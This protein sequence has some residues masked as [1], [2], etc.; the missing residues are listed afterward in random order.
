MSETDDI[1]ARISISDLVSG[2]GVNL[3]RAGDHMVACCPLHNEKTPSFHVFPDTG[4]WR[5][6]GA[7]GKGGDIFDF[8]C[9][10]ENVEFRDALIELAKRAGVELKPQGGGKQGQERR[11]KLFGVLAA[12]K[13]FYE[14]NL[15]AT[16]DASALDYISSRG[17]SQEMIAEWGIG[18]APAGWR[19][20]YDYLHSIGYTDDQL[21]LDSGAFK[22]GDKGGVYDAFRDRLI[23]PIT[24]EAGQVISFAGRAM[25]KEDN[26]K[27]LNGSATEIFEKNSV[28]FGFHQA[29]Q[30]IRALNEVVLVEG[31][32]DV[33]FAH[34][35]GFKSVVGS[36]GTAFTPAH[37]ELLVKRGAGRVVLAFDPDKAGDNANLRGVITMQTVK[38]K[39]IDLRVLRLPDERDPDELILA[40]PETWRTLVQDATP[41]VLFVL[42]MLA[43]HVDA[44]TQYAEREQIARTILPIITAANT[45]GQRRENVARLADYVRIAADVLQGYIKAPPIA[46]DS[47]P[48]ARGTVP[49]VENEF[50]AGII[51]K[52]GYFALAQRRCNTLQIGKLKPHDLTSPEHRALLDMLIAA[53]DQVD[54]DDAEYIEENAPDILSRLYQR[55]SGRAL[56]EEETINAGLWLRKATFERALLE[57]QAVPEQVDL[58][59]RLIRVLGIA[60]RALQ[61]L[62]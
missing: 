27:Y 10:K 40:E 9:E 15:T 41:A 29:K 18:Y 49:E 8:Y 12:L 31:Y 32:M 44:K 37:A 24:N 61:K 38:D 3:K 36:M 21:L 56:G 2:Y 30:A 62:C 22:R 34:L 6:F 4:R 45:E 42:D 47:L 46:P 39:A 16:V 57:L 54:L 26:P 59:Q 55:L 58:L 52:P 7:C 35:A 5:C 17:A 50:L 13:D 20:A 43:G 1:K 11:E 25:K 28:L 51:A 48:V 60:T 33:M 53:W 19:N 23:I 14:A